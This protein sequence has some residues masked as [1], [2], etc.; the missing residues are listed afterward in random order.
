MNIPDKAALIYNS[1]R[2]RIFLTLLADMVS[3]VHGCELS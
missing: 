2:C 3:K 1:D